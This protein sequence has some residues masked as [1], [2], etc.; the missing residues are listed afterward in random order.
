MFLL[1]ATTYIGTL[2]HDMSSLIRKFVAKLGRKAAAAG[3][4]ARN[5]ANFAIRPFSS[6]LTRPDLNQAR[7]FR[8]LIVHYSAPIGHEKQPTERPRPVER[9]LVLQLC[10]H[11]TITFERMQRILAL[12][13]F[14][15]SF[16]GIEDLGATT[17]PQHNKRSPNSLRRCN[18]LG[19]GDLDGTSGYI[20]LRHD[21]KR[22]GKAGI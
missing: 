18:L 1:K 19:T 11:E 6:Q 16:E 12:P 17:V 20:Q 2:L 14:K 9:R 4:D 8:R 5:S 21:P 22:T 3:D 15:E 10:T 7:V 13:K